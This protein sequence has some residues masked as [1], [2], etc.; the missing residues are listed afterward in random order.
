YRVRKTGEFRYVH[1]LNGTALATTRTM[2]AIVENFQREDGSIE[3]PKP[4]RE[5]IGKDVIP[6]ET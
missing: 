1:T 2:V 5:I 3:V 6:G 4:L